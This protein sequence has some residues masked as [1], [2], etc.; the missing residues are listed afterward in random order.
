M[1]LGN[2]RLI[3][4]PEMLAKLY[5][6]LVRVARGTAA[7][8]CVTDP[9]GIR[10][11]IFRVFVRKFLQLKRIWLLVRRVVALK[12]NSTKNAQNQSDLV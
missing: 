2:V 6:D 4:L 5:T 1:L 10:L 9:V 12:K 11:D 3:I 7:A 8:S